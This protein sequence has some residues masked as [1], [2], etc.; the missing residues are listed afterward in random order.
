MFPYKMGKVLIAGL[1]LNK[2]NG[3]LRKRVQAKKSELHSEA[4]FYHLIVNG[5]DNN[6]TEPFKPT[7]PSPKLGYFLL[8]QNPN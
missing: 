5:F 2:C 6:Q 1:S 3:Q 8:N 4:A 7:E